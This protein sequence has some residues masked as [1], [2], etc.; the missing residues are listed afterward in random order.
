[1]KPVIITGKGNTERSFETVAD[2]NGE[3]E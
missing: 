2:R 3:D 1:M